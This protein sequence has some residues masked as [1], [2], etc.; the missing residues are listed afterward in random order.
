MNVEKLRLSRYGSKWADIS[1]QDLVVKMKFMVENRD[2][3][4]TMG[5][6]GMAWVTETFNWQKVGNTIKEEIWKVLKK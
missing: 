4:K 2:V 1:I 3:G 6:F 5:R